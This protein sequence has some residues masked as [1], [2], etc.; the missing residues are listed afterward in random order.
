MFEYIHRVI[1]TKILD[2]QDIF[3]VI[4]ITGPRQSG[5]S[6]LCRHLFAEYRY[7]NLENIT[8]RVR[9]KSDPVGFVDSLGDNVIIDEVQNVPEVLSMIQVRV[10]EFPTRRYVLTG[11]CNFTLLD[12]VSHSLAGRVAAFTLLPFAFS[13]LNSEKKDIATDC[14]MFRGF[15]PQTVLKEANPVDFYSNYY[16]NYVEKDIRDILKVKNLVKFD[17]FLRLLALRVG[18]EFNASSMSK[19]VGVSAPTI[20]EWMALLK[21]SYI[22]CEIPPYYKNLGKQL[23]KMHKIYFCDTGLLCYLLGAENPQFVSK[24]TLYGS[25]FENMAVMELVKDRFNIGR[26][27]GICFYRERSGF[28]VDAL[29]PVKDGIEAYEIKSGKTLRPDYLENLNKLKEKMPDL[30][31]SVVIYDGVSQG[32]SLLNIRDI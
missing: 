4:L 19:E 23:T 16:N 8:D 27:P 32:S 5:K 30:A 7:V 26:N 20:S 12:S 9:A 13:E 1:E 17:T 6:T 31:G 10:D 15:Y 25:I 11:S 29:V 24:T 22:I 28:E 2:V 18:S 14:L 21:V 3:P